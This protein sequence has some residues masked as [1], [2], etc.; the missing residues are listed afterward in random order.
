MRKK[1][2]SLARARLD[3]LDMLSCRFFCSSALLVLSGRL[4]SSR[5]SPL[6][7][8]QRK[9][10]GWTVPEPQAWREGETGLRTGWSRE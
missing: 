5:T 2:T 4:R 6:Y 7:D 9:I 8:A 1:N 10:E 3:M